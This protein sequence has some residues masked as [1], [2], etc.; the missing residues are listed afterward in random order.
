MFRLIQGICSLQ[1]QKIPWEIGCYS[2]CFR[3]ADIDYLLLETLEILVEFLVEAQKINTQ[4]SWL[5]HAT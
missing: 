2:L 1:W 3:T 5:E 4:E